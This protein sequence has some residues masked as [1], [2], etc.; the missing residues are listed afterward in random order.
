MNY[1][2]LQRLAWKDA[3]SIVP[4][5]IAILLL[6]VGFNILLGL[7]FWSS[8]LG[9]TA[10]ERHWLTYGTWIL[11]PNLFALGVPALLVGSEEESGSLAWLRTLPMDW[12]SV[13]GTKLLLAFI[14]YV[15]LFVV[16]LVCYVIQCEL[17]PDYLRGAMNRQGVFPEPLWI[18]AVGQVF[19]GLTLMLVSFT[20]AFL[21]RSPVSSLVSVAPVMAGLSFSFTRLTDGMTASG[22]G[23]SP[24]EFALRNHFV[25][26]L[27]F[28]VM[29][30][31]LV[32]GLLAWSARRRLSDRDNTSR[33]QASAET[34]LD[35]FQPPSQSKMLGAWCGEFVRPTRMRVMIWQT[36]RQ[37]GWMLLVAFGLC[38]AS[39]ICLTNSVGPPLIGLGFAIGILVIGGVTFYGDAV[40]CRFSFY[41]DRGISPSQIW[42]SRVVPTL[43][44]MLAVIV[45]ICVIED[46]FRSPFVSVAGGL[47]AVY[48]GTQLTS[49][50]SPRPILVFFLAPVVF[51]LSG[52]AVEPLASSRYGSS[53][54]FWYV[55]GVLLFASWRMM[56]FWLSSK[57][58]PGF[59]A[60]F[61]GYLSLAVLMPYVILLA[62]QWI[63]L[64]SED[65]QWRKETMALNTITGQSET[66]RIESD[67]RRTTWGGDLFATERSLADSLQVR[68]RK[69]LDE[70]A[71]IAKHV[72]FDDLLFHMAYYP[73]G[74]PRNGYADLAVFASGGADHRVDRDEQDEI[75]A[76]ANGCRERDLEAAQV[77]AKWSNAIREASMHERLDFEFLASSAEQADAFTL[78]ILLTHHREYGNDDRL[79]EIY[80][81][82][83]DR[84][85]VLAS[86]RQ[87]LIRTWQ[88]YQTHGLGDVNP[89]EWQVGDL[90]LRNRTRR[91]QMP[92]QWWLGLERKRIRREFDQQ[93]RRTLRQWQPGSG[94]IE[95][96]LGLN[97]L[98]ANVLKTQTATATIMANDALRR[99][100]ELRMT[101]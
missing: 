35:A 87:A 8:D 96:A 38:V 56:P 81:A 31:G 65:T 33:F 25:F 74:M 29:F 18:H 28:A 88:D 83:P 63:S 21:L 46:E 44:V 3:R 80:Q 13:A 62:G 43:G 9:S 52:L 50:W 24:W 48:A 6:I 97:N 26:T 14:G 75:E 98:L 47:I 23:S 68:I 67:A 42:L 94:P 12:K 82:M 4:F 61:A 30:F 59:H 54:S 92:Q 11:L 32:T 77:L 76:F 90:L 55:A 27:G 100:L 69:E 5:T 16:A 66:S 95:S 39:V 86:R 51:V 19:F 45:S 64:P 34:A 93:V 17:I 37:N 49:L 79:R 70:K 85:L 2:I 7:L 53:W 57:R 73:S 41:H 10:S 40:R 84:E 72:S 99:E 89:N 78:S 22:F 71:R 60:R 91:A 20:T 36:V 15:C 58:G 101:R 1:K